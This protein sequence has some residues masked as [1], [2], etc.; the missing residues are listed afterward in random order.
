M[1]IKGALPIRCIGFGYFRSAF[2]FDAAQN[3]W[4]LVL[5]PA[6]T[7]SEIGSP[8]PQGPFFPLSDVRFP[9]LARRPCWFA[10]ALWVSHP[11]LL[12]LHDAALDV[13]FLCAHRL[14]YIS[15]VLRLG[16]LLIWRSDISSVPLYFPVSG[17]ALHR[18]GL[19]R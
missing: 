10:L 15:L 5:L 18:S 16:C 1:H 4:A 7:A 9:N 19:A 11:A 2:G 13:R 12:H 3:K 6:P 14:C 8:W 17:P